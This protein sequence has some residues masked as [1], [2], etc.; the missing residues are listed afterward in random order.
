MYEGEQGDECTLTYSRICTSTFVVFA[1]AL[2][3]LG[4]CK[5]AIVASIYMPM[6]PELPIAM[7]ACARIG[8]VHSVIFG[9]FSSE[10]IADRNQ[11]R[12]GANW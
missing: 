2:K 12:Q 1:N 5:R 11:R 8:V 10:A 9:G 3:S 6:T 7:L 4:I